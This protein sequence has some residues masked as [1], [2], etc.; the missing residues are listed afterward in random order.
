MIWQRLSF[1]LLA[2]TMMLHA[3]SK[4]YRQQR[5]ESHPMAGMLPSIRVQTAY[6]DGLIEQ[7]N[8][9]F[10]GISLRSMMDQVGMMVLLVSTESP[11][12]HAD[13]KI[14]DILLEIE[15]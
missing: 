6:C 13:M 11:A 3:Y 10:L 1:S 15:G 12:W 5:E 4:M 9:P 2:S 7:S 8:R 14:G